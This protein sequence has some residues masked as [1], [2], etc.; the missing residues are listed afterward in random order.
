MFDRTPALPGAPARGSAISQGLS[1]LGTAGG[2]GISI[3][4]TPLLFGLTEQPL[5]SYLA[6]HWG[7][8]MAS[9]L[10]WV[11]FG[12]EGVIAYVLTKLT[13]V[14]ALTAAIVTLAARRIPFA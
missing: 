12:V 2:I 5:H 7:P 6:K 14:S 3:L 9:V 8:D 13:I 11:M 10:S 4:L 1:L